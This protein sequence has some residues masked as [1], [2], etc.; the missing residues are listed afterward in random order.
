MKKNQAWGSTNARIQVT[1]W[2]KDINQ[3]LIKSE[4][5]DVIR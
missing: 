2:L 5:A 3:Y 4:M 1:S